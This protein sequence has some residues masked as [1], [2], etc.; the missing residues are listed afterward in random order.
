M[1]YGETH[2]CI[3]YLTSIQLLLSLAVQKNWKLD[4]FDVITALLNSNVNDNTLFVGLPEGWPKHGPRGRPEEVTVVRL[5]KALYGLKQAPHLS[6][7]HINAFVLFLSSIQSEADPNHD[8]RN[9]GE[10]LLLLY[11]D[12]MLLAYAPTVANTLE[13]IKKAIAATYKITNLGTAQQFLRIV[14]HFSNDG[15]SLLKRFHM[16]T[17]HGA[18]TP[19][20]DKVMLDLV[21]EDRERDGEVDP[22]QYQ[23]IVGYLMYIALATR[24]DISIAVAALSQYNSSPFAWHL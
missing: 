3:G 13:E 24:P 6:Y 1:D 18:A 10:M 2:A 15:I 16:E 14:I 23:A 19:L 20:D 9:L 22:K 11:V 5:R 21:D 8:I 4:R 12:D 17:A 7:R